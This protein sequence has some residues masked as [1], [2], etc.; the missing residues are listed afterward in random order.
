[1]DGVVLLLVSVLVLLFGTMTPGSWFLKFS[2]KGIRMGVG[3][4]GER[5]AGSI[6]ILSR[7]GC[8]AWLLEGDGERARTGE[9]G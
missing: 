1:V 5:R 8:G 9:R 7:G 2:K 6:C 3:D 4:D